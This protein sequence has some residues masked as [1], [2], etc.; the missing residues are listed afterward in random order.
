MNHRR[1]ADLARRLIEACGG[2]E[3]AAT[4]CRV[5]KSQLSAYQNPH[6]PSTM[7]ADVMHDLEAYC[8]ENLYSREIAEA[9][10]SA[11]VAGDAITET[12]E[13][14]VAAAALLPLA[15]ALADGKPGAAAAY[16]GAVARLTSEV[17][18]VEAIGN[19]APLRAV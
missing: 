4:A 6:E 14:V 1:H 13:V 16:R 17:D 12:H 11:P 8:G 15:I 3:E 10:P 9:R 5:K 19:V 7:P 2:L 18:D